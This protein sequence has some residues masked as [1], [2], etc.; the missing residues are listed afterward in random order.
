MLLSG[1]EQSGLPYKSPNIFKKSNI[2][3]Y[4]ERP[5][6]TFCNGKYS[7][8]GDFCDAEFLAY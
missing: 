4:L 6:A 5:S 7:I 8:L 1:K 2:D 3:C